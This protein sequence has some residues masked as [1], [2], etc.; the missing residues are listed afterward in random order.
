MLGSRTFDLLVVGGGI[1]GCGV[2][3]EAALHGLSVALVEQDDFASGTSSRSSRLV[4][5]GV[6]Y[7]EHGHLNLVFESSRERRELL[8][9]AP[10]LVHPLEFVWPVY[11]GARISLWKLGAGLLLYDALSLFRN[12]ARHHRL[13]PA[14]VL[15]KEPALEA[16][17]LV[18]GAIYYDAATN[19]ARLT[20]A[21]AISALE[22]GAVVLNHAAATALSMDGSR[23]TGATVQD[24]LGG[25][26]VQVRA[27]VV[28]NAT[29]P[30]S[31]DV[32]SLETPGVPTVRGSKGSHIE[33]PRERIGNRNALTLLS[34]V[35]GRVLF[36]LPA[37][38]HAIIGTTETDTTAAPSEVRA[39][40]ADVQ[41]L[42]AAANTFFPA[43]R[44]Q[45]DDVVSAWAGIRP[46][47]P[48]AEGSAGAVTREHAI[49]IS[50][51]G[52]VSIVGGKL[53]TYR[54][55]ARDVV[56]A[57]LRVLRGRRVRLK[58]SA[59]PLPGGELASVDE[60]VDEIT[61]ATSDAAMSRHL[62]T[63]F[64]SRWRAVWEEIGAPGGRDRLVDGLPYTVGEARYSLQ[65][66]MAC[67][68][69]D[70]LI[71]RTHI[72]FETRDH[73]EAVAERVAALAAAV[74]G[75]NA[76]DVR[77]ALLD[78]RHDVTRM[79]SVDP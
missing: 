17:G 35:D 23:I 3:R 27:S 25:G 67:T 69:G 72:A 24:R 42:L 49:S 53:T 10:H 46:L 1:T 44:L 51:H 26:V 20:L 16:E 9:I 4:H 33:V 14:Q 57:V 65:Q 58:P 36:A 12:V 78:Y 18:G 29:G 7:L 34:P 74:H 54:V 59:Q 76:V 32:R 55:M 79:F 37:G 6:R 66:E 70:L 52:L 71:R 31:D 62:A 50:E 60:L 11:A 77:A 39:S 61:S 48:V 75:W 47:L 56:A 28:V 64:G 13:T 68:L 40:N 21:N 43:A 30:W 5:G 45:A 15:E 22:A 2:A 38:A 73:G 19:D 8:E 41:Y 63:S